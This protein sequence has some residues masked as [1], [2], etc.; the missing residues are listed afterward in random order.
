MILNFLSNYI[1][2]SNNFLIACRDRLPKDIL[3]I[4]SD[5]YE[6]RVKRELQDSLYKLRSVMVVDHIKKISE[7][8]RFELIIYLINGK[9]EWDD[10]YVDYLT[11][12][13]MGYYAKGAPLY[14]DRTTMF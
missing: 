14:I 2:M 6:G 1:A 4:I 9:F 8:L 11:A 12:T 7:N 10:A 13:L 3:R 5:N